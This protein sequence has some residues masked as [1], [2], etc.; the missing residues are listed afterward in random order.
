MITSAWHRIANID[1]RSLALFRVALAVSFIIDLFTYFPDFNYL[2]SDDGIF[3]RNNLVWFYGDKGFSLFLITGHPLLARALFGIGYVA[4]LAL[5][6]GYRCR[7]S[8]CILLLLIASINNRVPPVLY[9]ADTQILV[10]LF[11]S[12]F[13]PLGAR[14]SV[15]H[16]LSR[17]ELE[18]SNNYATLAT[19][20]ILLQESYVY[21]FGALFKVSDVW[22]KDYTAI[23]WALGM[24]DVKRAF[25]EYFVQ[26]P[27][28]LQY[29]TA[30]VYYLE[31]TCIFFLFLP[32]FTSWTRLVM[33]ILLA[34][35]NLGFSIFLNVGY[36]PIISITGLFIFVPD[37]V[38]NFAQR[39]IDQYFSPAQHIIY[40]DEPCDFCYKT[41]LIFR[42][43]SYLQAAGIEPAQATPEIYTIMQSENS[44]VIKTNTGALLTKWNAVTYLWLHS[45]IFF[46]FGAIFCLPFM[47]KTGNFLYKSIATNRGRIA[48]LSAH[49]LPFHRTNITPG[50][51]ANTFLL[52]MIA[53][54]LME[55]IYMTIGTGYDKMPSLF[56]EIIE[57]T[58]TYQTWKMYTPYP[59][60]YSAW[61]RV[62]GV[63]ENGETWD[64]LFD[65]KWDWK[66]QIPT[67]S[68]AA[69]PSDR[70]N[71]YF[72]YMGD[73]ALSQLY[74]PG[75]CS[76]YNRTHDIKMQVIT[77]TGYDRKSVINTPTNTWPLK[78]RTIFIYHCDTAIWDKVDTTLHNLPS[79]ELPSTAI[80]AEPQ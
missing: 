26:F 60:N 29:L 80:P 55:N 70:I 8:C 68:M 5:L 45:P 77:V 20:A 63:I 52:P 17:P 13:L 7:I 74:G 75:M 10:L 38:W 37:L 43:L 27:A 49:F 34:S 50:L 6:V 25:T 21:F 54:V 72:G 36:F 65:K 16:A 30:Y 62:S 32:I 69:F 42:D 41:C 18:T 39:K 47:T 61:V 59:R 12:I 9:Y 3:P 64:M 71:R 51:L 66:Y 67:Y 73:Y 53:L 79:D 48:K 23:Q 35:L 11:W 57:D 22:R 4:A 78:M 44:W 1:L 76:V 15:D 24:L 58:Q 33:F 40:Y 2:F 46:M 19:F 28:F 56:K 14:F 31:L